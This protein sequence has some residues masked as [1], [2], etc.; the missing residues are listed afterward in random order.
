VNEE[1]AREVMLR[2]LA[3]IA[4]DA[5]L[6]TIDPATPLGEQLDLDSIDLF[7]LIV[8]VAERTGVEVP[9]RD[10]PQLATLDGAVAYLVAS[11][12]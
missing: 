9:E 1:R 6:G 3:E 8:L 4:P 5:D 10:Y 2:A 11:R 7:N 12:R